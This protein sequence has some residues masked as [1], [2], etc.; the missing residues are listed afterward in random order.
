[1][2]LRMP[3]MNGF[4]AAAAIRN[5]PETEKIVIVAA[6]ASSADLERADA[7]RST[8]ALCLRK[9]FQ[10]ADLLDAIAQ[11]LGLTWHYAEPQPAAGI[12]APVAPMILP[13]QEVLEELVELAR[14]GKLVR[15][16]QIARDLRQ[17]D[18]RLRPFADRLTGLARGFDEDGLSAL[19]HDALETRRHAISP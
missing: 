17:R 9:P 1:M 16:E 6:S 18:K 13:A 4:D 19:L 5:A 7:D 2:D 8:F 10:T 12:S 11:L 14:L 3:Q 15:V